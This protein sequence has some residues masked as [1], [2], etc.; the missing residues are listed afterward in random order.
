MNTG[1]FTP[2]SSLIEDTVYIVVTEFDKYAI[3]EADLVNKDTV[4]E[5]KC[6]IFHNGENI[7][8]EDTPDICSV[9]EIYENQL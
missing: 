1:Y 3:I 2:P 5:S 7:T 4:K 8:A 9:Y 6:A